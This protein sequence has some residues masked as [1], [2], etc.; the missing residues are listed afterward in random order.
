M[1]YEPNESYLDRI[2]RLKS[3][4][5]TAR[6]APTGDMTAHTVMPSTAPV[7][8]APTAPTS[9]SLSYGSLI[10]PSRNTGGQRTWMDRGEGGGEWGYSPDNWDLSGL[11]FGTAYTNT[12]GV[13]QKAMIQGW[14]FRN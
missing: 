9:N 11:D 10:D 2:T 12:S 13:D 7:A 8:S 1:T 3:G 5:G 6:T 14:Y 4:A